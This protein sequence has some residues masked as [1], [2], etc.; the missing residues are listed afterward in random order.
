MSIFFLGRTY[1]YWTELERR[2][3]S[4]Q[5]GYRASELLQEVVEL[6][7]KLAFYEARIREMATILE[8]KKS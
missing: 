3:T 6:R 4:E 5:D 1:E 2:I 8:P 7:G